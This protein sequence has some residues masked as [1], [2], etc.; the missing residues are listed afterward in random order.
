MR[1]VRESKENTMKKNTSQKN[2][3][4]IAADTD[5]MFENF[6]RGLGIDKEGKRPT[7]EQERVIRAKDRTMLVIAG[8]GSGKT[9]T[10]SQR[11]A[12]HIAAEGIKPSEVLGLTFT[13]K[14]AG[15]L[16][17]RVQGYLHALTLNAHNFPYVKADSEEFG[18]PTISTYNSFASDIASSYALLIGEDP[19]SVLISETQ[20]WQIMNSIVRAWDTHDSAA[21]PS[22]DAFD[23]ARVL[24]DQ[25]IDT[26]IDVA[27]SMAAGIIDNGLTIQQVRDELM[28]E[29]ESIRALDS[30]KT[31]FSGKPYSG[32][33]VSTAFRE[34]KE[35]G[36]SLECR[37]AVLDIVEA[38]F[39]YK[40]ENGYIEFA[41]QV[42]WARRIL[43]E[44]P[45]IGIHLRKKYRLVVLDEYQDTS[46]NQAQFLYSALA[47]REGE[48][49]SVCAVGDPNQAIYGWRGA[50]ANALD[51][52]KT[53]FCVH[54]D[55]CLS[56]S[57][58]FRNSSNILEAANALVASDMSIDVQS[59]LED[60]RNET[61]VNAL[62]RPWLKDVWHPASY[63]LQELK[64][65]PSNT[66]GEVVH[67]H[68][69]LGTDTYDAIARRIKEEFD[70]AYVRYQHEQKKHT[71]SGSGNYEAPTAAVL[72]RKRK[73]AKEMIEALNRYGVRFDYLGGDSI[74][75]QKEIRLLRSFLACAFMPQRNDAFVFVAQFY[76][77]GVHDLR[78]LAE[79][80]KKLDKASSDVRSRNSR[81]SLRQLPITFSEVAEY[82]YLSSA[83]A[84]ENLDA[85]LYNECEGLAQ[86]VDQ[87][88]ETGRL[89]LCRIGGMLRD[90]RTKTMASV[91]DIV[92]YA[93]DQLDLQ[94]YISARTAGKAR[95]K[96]NLAKFISL[97]HEF[98]PLDPK[99]CAVGANGV[100]AFLTQLNHAEEKERGEDD[101]SS[102]D[103]PVV[104]CDDI[105]PEHGVVQIL[106]VHAAKGLEWDIVGIPEMVDGE[107][108]LVSSRDVKPWHKD[109][110]A[111]PFSLRGDHRY[112]PQF[113]ARDCYT[114][115]SKLTNDNAAE[116]GSRYFLYKNVSCKEYANEEIKHLAYVAVTRP[117]SLLLLATYDY[118][119]EQK[120]L[121]V[122]ETLLK[123]N[124][125]LGYIDDSRSDLNKEYLNE[126][127]EKWT[128]PKEYGLVQKIIE[129]LRKQEKHV[130]S[131]DPDNDERIATGHEFVAWMRKR[132]SDD[133]TDSDNGVS[134]GAD[135]DMNT[136][137]NT[138]LD[139][140]EQYLKQYASD[141]EIPQGIPVWPQSVD[142]SL[143]SKEDV[144]DLYRYKSPQ[145][146]AKQ[147]KKTAERLLYLQR[148][149][150]SAESIEFD[151]LTASGIVHLQE[152]P[153]SFLKNRQRPIPQ[154]PS[155]S[156]DR[157]TKVHA[158]IAR[159]F[160]APQ[161][162]DIDS[163]AADTAMPFDESKELSGDD[164]T[165]LFER[166]TSSD[167]ARYP[168]LAVEKSID[169]AI[170]DYPVRC[171]LDAVFDTHS[172]EGHAPVT[173][174]DWK[175]GKQP[176]SESLESRRLQLAIYRYAWAHAHA[177]D[178]DNID[179]F[180]Y[181][182]G[183]DDPSR[184]LLHP[185]ALSYEELEERIRT[186][187]E[188]GKVNARKPRNM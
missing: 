75:V 46:V 21:V 182:L 51:D 134:S 187:I 113:N 122:Y 67:I 105:E 13:R 42:A 115:I 99:E 135:A 76:G 146:L 72:I 132:A 174:V 65:G 144:Q 32:T 45:D 142:R 106:T 131:D 177:I 74:L 127:L 93:A 121:R 30:A 133:V 57:T 5:A 125:Q 77:I 162:L 78:T 29:R 138:D 79:I 183:E 92:R 23:S 18:R 1:S 59:V 47:P 120:M 116:A 38:Y 52:Y 176:D 147:W 137:E 124:P 73:Y 4:A 136:T 112:L 181:Y 91:P 118:K 81:S 87:L 7:L 97:A 20:R 109:R 48:D 19:M 149:R 54:N 172:L 178:V 88:T 175:T 84:P 158:K 63:M 70:S 156:A 12:W 28:N 150:N 25:S 179:A 164:I 8:A 17:E 159:Y 157:G 100:S 168:V 64:P 126:P 94:G 188:Q 171:V 107:F 36:S 166:F 128:P 3:R 60:G 11:I 104:T 110:E 61:K 34:L 31:G 180:F 89:R 123:E 83:K 186:A 101:D 50:G 14:A 119:D 15:E 103:L 184:R 141:C 66:E 185:P 129:A 53:T 82:L 155:L 35:S 167:F 152:D 39:A 68:R 161:M 2:S 151:H 56:L 10:M 55:A 71:R 154:A 90:V 145:D 111:I 49:I 24:G 148:E 26:I 153:E 163:V 85:N 62:D 96:R 165:M 173:I 117:K 95:A 43:N 130:I 58:A 140:I 114:D 160:N 102:A 86:C 80:R 27:L 40:R 108:G 41:D 6:L 143:I 9:A 139:V 33:E 16:A 169:Y 69:T 98:F 37:I 22:D 170:G 44:V